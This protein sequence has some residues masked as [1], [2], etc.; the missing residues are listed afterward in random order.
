MPTFMIVVKKISMKCFCNTMVD[1]FGKNFLPQNFLAIKYTCSN[2]LHTFTYL[3]PYK[4]C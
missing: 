2:D 4:C 3:L 1:G